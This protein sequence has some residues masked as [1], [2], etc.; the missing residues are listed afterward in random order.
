MF[1]GYSVPL[2][3]L[4]HKVFGNK[5][6]RSCTPPEEAYITSSVISQRF[7]S[8]AAYQHNEHLSSVE[9]LVTYIQQK[10]C[11]GNFE[12]IA[13]VE[14]VRHADYLDFDYDAITQSV[15]LSAFWVRSPGTEERWNERI[16]RRKTSDRVEVGVFSQEKSTQP[17]EISLG[18]YLAVVGKD[19]KPSKLHP[20]ILQNLC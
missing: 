7:A 17:E 20:S 15:L 19:S 1:I 2:C 14:R 18:G 3:P 9:D 12:C 11:L 4:L 6:W 10:V 13:E 8:S 5:N 16:G